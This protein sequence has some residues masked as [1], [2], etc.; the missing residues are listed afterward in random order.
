MNTSWSLI[1]RFWGGWVRASRCGV[2][3]KR[4]AAQQPRLEALEGR[5]VL[6]RIIRTHSSSR[7]L[8]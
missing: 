5:V 7:H 6:T 4:R 3:R 8:N 2:V 1:S